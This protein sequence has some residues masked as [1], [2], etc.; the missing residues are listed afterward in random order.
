MRLTALRKSI[1]IKLIEL[2][3][4]KEKENFSLYDFAKQFQKIVYTFF[5]V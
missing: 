2:F 1:K 3:R 5:S 4:I